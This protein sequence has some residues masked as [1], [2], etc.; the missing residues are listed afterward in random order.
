MAGVGF[1]I[2]I[3]GLERFRQARLEQAQGRIRRG[4][5]TAL[6]T[7]VHLVRRD[8]VLN[9]PHVSGR[10]RSSIRGRVEHS[11]LLGGSFGVVGSNVVYARIQELGGV[12]K[13]RHAKY[14]TIPLSGAKTKAG[15]VRGSARSFP[16]TF[17]M[18]SRS[19]DLLIVQRRGQGVLPLFVL[20]PEITIRGK[21]YLERG[22]EQNRAAIRSLFG[23]E[24]KA[25]LEA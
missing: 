16:D 11:A 13:A 8:A 9:A 4:I 5:A 14:L 24:V 15:V 20:K 7:A 3:E 22:L 25:A 2:V 1:K 19:G 23:R 18:R 12:I 21:H 6:E 17:V 10:L